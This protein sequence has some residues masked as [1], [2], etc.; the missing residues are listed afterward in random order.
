MVVNDIISD[1]LTRI[2]NAN[3][4]KSSKVLVPRTELTLSIANILKEEGF[5][6]SFESS[7]NLD[8]R[9]FSILLKYKGLNNKP[10]ITC[11]KRISKPGLRVYINFSNIPQV[12]GGIGIAILENFIFLLFYLSTSHGV[13]TNRRA[14]LEKYGGEVLFYI[15]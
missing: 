9:F 6:D 7:P 2:R 3:L 1:F 8:N 5:I 13:M 15:W 14:R 4:I 10:Y 11:L 12:L